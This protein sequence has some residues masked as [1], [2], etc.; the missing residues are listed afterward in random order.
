MIEDYDNRTFQKTGDIV[1]RKIVDETILVP[2]QGELAS[3]RRVFSLTPVADFI[4]NSIDGTST[5]KEIRAD[6]VRSFQVDE[7]TAKTD[8]S[9]LIEQL[10]EYRLIGEA[11]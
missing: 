9:E 4:W 6:V 11:Q 3:M 7:E 5:V 8:I 10:I 2:V 1:A